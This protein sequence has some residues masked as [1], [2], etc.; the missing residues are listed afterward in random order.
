MSATMP[1]AGGPTRVGAQCPMPANAHAKDRPVCA[2]AFAPEL[3]RELRMRSADGWAAAW[4]DSN[5]P[6]LCLPCTFFAP[7]QA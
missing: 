7:L 4:R 2:P 6:A 1:F 5:A 3:A